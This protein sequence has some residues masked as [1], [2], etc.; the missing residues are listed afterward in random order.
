MAGAEDD[1]A[2]IARAAR[3]AGQLALAFRARGLKAWDKAA[4]DPVSEADIAADTLLKDRLI[5]A[6]PGYGWLSEE[7]ADDRSR[8]SAAR[9]FVVDPIDGTRA[10][11]KGRPEFVVSVAVIENGA[12]VAAAVYDPS[13]ERLWDAAL[14]AGARLNGQPVRMSGHG[15]IAGARLLGDPG[16][17]TALRDMGATASTVNSAALRLAL[18]ASGLFDGVVAVRPKWDWDLAAG[19]LLV[20]EAGG[21]ITDRAGDVLRYDR[22]LPRQPAPLA[23]GPAL[24]A[25][26][27]ERLAQEEEP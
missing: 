12:P 1:R 16:R 10:F 20:T 17:L 24:H 8:L 7:T 25:L 6:R 27:L 14:G 18:A 9:S 13:T 22:D 2:L 23:A 4:G 21:R 5:P 15:V 11:L 3:D 19:H 26:L